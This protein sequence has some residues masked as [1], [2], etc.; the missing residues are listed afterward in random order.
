MEHRLYVDHC[1]CNDII[2]MLTVGVE[3]GA[4]AT[5]IS[6]YVG[7][8]PVVVASATATFLLRV[9]KQLIDNNDEGEGIVIIAT[10]GILG[11]DLTPKGLEP[12]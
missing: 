9:G 12:Q 1:N 2:D 6:G 11:D 10:S 3:A 7:N 4:L 5:V 8:L